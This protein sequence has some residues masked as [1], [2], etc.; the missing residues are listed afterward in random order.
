MVYC[1]EVERLENL[2]K[3]QQAVIDSL[4]GEKTGRWM[5][6][7]DGRDKE[8]GAIYGFM[9]LWDIILKKVW[10]ITVTRTQTRFHVVFDNIF[11]TPLSSHFPLKGTMNSPKVVKQDKNLDFLF[12][13]NSD[14]AYLGWVI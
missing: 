9:V 14:T 8:P 2:I 4:M 10:E 3:K 7:M 5:E 13:N 6:E 12:R 1:Q 11:A